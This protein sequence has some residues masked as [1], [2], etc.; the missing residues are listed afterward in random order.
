MIVG[1][2]GAGLANLVF[3][4]PGTRV[5]EIV[6][7][8]NAYPFYF[9]LAVGAGLDYRYLVARSVQERGAEAF[10]PSPFHFNVRLDELAIALPPAREP[11]A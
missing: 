8:D 2:H 4:R 6:P 7:T 11:V 10:G 1:A 5:V 3:C 9:S